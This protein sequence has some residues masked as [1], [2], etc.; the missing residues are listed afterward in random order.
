MLATLCLEVIGNRVEALT[1]QVGRKQAGSGRECSHGSCAS[2]RTA[3][4]MTGF[5][6]SFSRSFPEE[7]NARG[8]ASAICR[9]PRPS[10]QCPEN[11]TKNVNSENKRF[12]VD[13]MRSLDHNITA[14]AFVTASNWAGDAYGDAGH[15][16]W[17]V[18]RSIRN[19]V[20]GS[21]SRSGGYD[22]FVV[23]PGFNHSGVF[24]SELEPT[25]TNAHGVRDRL[26]VMQGGAEPDLPYNK[27]D[28]RWKKFYHTTRLG[29]ENS[30][31]YIENLLYQL[32]HMHTCNEAVR[33]YE[34]KS[35][36]AYGY[37][38]RMRP[39]QAWASPFPPLHALDELVSNGSIILIPSSDFW[40]YGNQDTFAFGTASAM[41]AYLDRGLV[42]H[43][44]PGVVDSSTWT[45]E[46]FVAQYLASLNMTL[47]PHSGIRGL[48]V[49]PA[50]CTDKIGHCKE[51]QAQKDCRAQKDYL[52]S[53]RGSRP[54]T[55]GEPQ[56]K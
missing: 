17:L 31:A 4:C 19:H 39:D 11:I 2:H 49:R 13:F 9:T 34:Q 38:M 23:E 21:L 12:I 3:I 27:S 14:E 56:Q 10:R 54:F 44:F 46:D 45:A 18:A 29:I 33:R 51:P 30:H 42:I 24:E 37:K 1:A 41:D 28:V 20:L 22:L 52:P 43:D 55:G 26:F 15:P 5:L 53:C 35:G 32:E 48:N 47:V 36:R 50:D 8:F 25:T 40:P 16:D 6:R 7:V